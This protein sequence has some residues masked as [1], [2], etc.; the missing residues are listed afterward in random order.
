MENK[1]NLEMLLKHKENGILFAQV[2][3]YLI[4]KIKDI[5]IFASKFSIFFQKLDRSAKSVLCM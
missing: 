2:I 5:A 1:G 4:L 3:N